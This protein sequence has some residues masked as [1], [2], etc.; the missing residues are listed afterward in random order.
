MT[1]LRIKRSD[2]FDKK[3]NDSFDKKANDSKLVGKKFSS[4]NVSLVNNHD[5]AKSHQCKTDWDFLGC[6]KLYSMKKADER[7]DLMVK[8]KIC[9]R[10]GGMFKLNRFVRHKCTWK[11][12]KE[13]AKC[14]APN[15][16]CAAATCK[17]HCNTDNASKELKDWLSR[18]NVKYTCEHISYY[19]RVQ[20]V[21]RFPRAFDTN[22]QR[23]QY[24][25][26]MTMSRGRSNQPVTRELLQSG[27]MAMDMSD[28]EMLEHQIQR[29][30][31]MQL[32]MVYRLENQS[33]Y[34]LSSKAN[35]VIFKHSLIV[36]VTVGWLW[37]AY[38]RKNFSHQ[39]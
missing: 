18:N 37:M 26:C 8:N 9:F 19:D 24:R 16:S 11:N 25:E 22:I 39:N 36:D 21:D 38:H 3:A 28:D 15:C 6:I 5:C 31:K 27:E 14:T 35:V 10:C 2:L 23:P 20:R 17:D 7:R 33:S 32:F 4:N 12:G 1:I 30:N 13:K 34:S 29:L